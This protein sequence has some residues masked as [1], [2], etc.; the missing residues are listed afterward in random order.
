MYFV[1]IFLGPY[2]FTKGIFPLLSVP[3]SGKQKIPIP[4]LNQAASFRIHE[5]LHLMQ[6]LVNFSLIFI[7]G[8]SGNSINRLYKNKNPEVFNTSGFGHC[9]S[10]E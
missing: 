3:H 6:W 2:F 8:L 5:R 4:I 10:I 7:A 9:C 1:L